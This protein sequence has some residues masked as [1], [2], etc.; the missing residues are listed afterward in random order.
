MNKCTRRQCQFVGVKSCEMEDCPY[1]TEYDWIP[2]DIKMPNENGYYLVTVEFDYG[3]EVEIG[4]LLDGEWVNEN[5]HVTVAWQPLPE[6][7]E[8]R[9]K[10]D[11]TN[12]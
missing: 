12:E 5:S 10:I 4:W 8:I 7:F 6:P 1:R 3:K 11:D 9:R 2:C